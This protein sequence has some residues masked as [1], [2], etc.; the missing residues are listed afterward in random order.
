M[1]ACTEWTS[2]HRG[3]AINGPRSA[4]KEKTHSLPCDVLTF[5]GFQGFKNYSLLE[6][7]NVS[8]GEKTEIYFF[9]LMESSDTV[10]TYKKKS[11]YMFSPGKIIF[12]NQ[13]YIIKSNELI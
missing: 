5:G 2:K 9:F 12:K 4:K 11:S 13:F 8:R 10:I 1:P 3:S 7:V 6:I